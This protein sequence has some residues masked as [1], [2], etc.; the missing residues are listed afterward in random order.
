MIYTL[1]IWTV[2]AVAPGQRIYTDWRQLT[3][4]QESSELALKTKNSEIILKEKC[5][6]VAKELGLKP[7][8]YRC[9]RTK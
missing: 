1:F 7:E 9:V 8:I 5:E 4:I 3:T 2:V 6:Q